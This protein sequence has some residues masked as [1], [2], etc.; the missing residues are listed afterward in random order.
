[1]LEGSHNISNVEVI[2]TEKI[3]HCYIDKMNTEVT[4]KTVFS[5]KTSVQNNIYGKIGFALKQNKTQYYQQ[6]LLKTL[7]C[8]TKTVLEIYIVWL[9]KRRIVV[10]VKEISSARGT[11]RVQINTL[12]QNCIKKIYVYTKRSRLYNLCQL[13]QKHIKCR[14]QFG[15]SYKSQITLLKGIENSFGL[16]IDPFIIKYFFKNF[17]NRAGDFE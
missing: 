15:I 11:N 3:K 17:P 14:L 5:S 8:W 12:Q 9:E 1:V 16:G 2:V 13:R 10:Y 6:C 4:S 7:G